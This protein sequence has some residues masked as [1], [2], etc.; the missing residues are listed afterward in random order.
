M[1]TPQYVQ[2]PFPHCDQIFVA[3]KLFLGR[4]ILGGHLSPHATLMGHEPRPN[5][6]MNSRPHRGSNPACPA[7]TESLRYA[8]VLNVISA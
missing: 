7:S 4:K 6:A 1:Y 8:T 3:E 2:T 5:G